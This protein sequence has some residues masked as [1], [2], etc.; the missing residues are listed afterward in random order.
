[1]S[2]SPSFFLTFKFAKYNNEEQQMNG[3]SA[4][5]DCCQQSFWSL[6]SMLDFSAATQATCHPLLHFP[7]FATNFTIKVILW[8]L[9]SL[10][11]VFSEVMVVKWRLTDCA[12]RKVNRYCK[13]ASAQKQHEYAKCLCLQSAVEFHFFR[14]KIRKCIDKFKISAMFNYAK[15]KRI[16]CAVSIWK[17]YKINTLINLNSLSIEPL[18]VIRATFMFSSK[19]K[20]N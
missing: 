9:L 18:S 12:S 4:T 10:N 19:T 8:S 15:F 13:D 3:E 6:Y 5:L 2:S 20:R 7:L 16:P 14:L 1:M 11:H 17:P